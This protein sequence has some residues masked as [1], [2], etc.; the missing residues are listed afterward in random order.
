MHLAKLQHYQKHQKHYNAIEKS[1]IIHWGRCQ[2]RY[3]VSDLAMP[4]ERK[5]KATGSFAANQLKEE[6]LPEPSHVLTD[7]PKCFIS[8][9][10]PEPSQLFLY[11]AEALLVHDTCS[12]VCQHDQQWKCCYQANG[13]SPPPLGSLPPAES[14]IS[15]CFCFLNWSN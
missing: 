9:A 11:R 7:S 8:Q 3:S 6:I 10:S 4:V 2:P 13:A 5:N 14:L 1:K 15:H 12:R